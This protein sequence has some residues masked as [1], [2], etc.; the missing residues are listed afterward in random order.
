MKL[1]LLHGPPASGKLT[2]A[3]IVGE[4]TGFALFH[5]HLVVDAVAALFPFGSEPFVRLR[6]AM[7]MTLLG[8]AAAADR[9]T[10]FTYAPEASVTPG[11]IESLVETV[12]SRGGGVLAVALT[13]NDAEQERR[14]VATDRAR[15][16]KLT[17]SALL[18]EL[19][20]S[21]TAR[22]AA[23]PPSNLTID[24]TAIAPVDAAACIVEALG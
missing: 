13:I 18:R 22:T 14:L 4:R 24:T 12:R 10:I 20:P 21:M 7:W 16:G 2:I 1:V 19:R 17:D 15:F 6:E 3:R 5:N 23:M 9:D 8:E 11:F